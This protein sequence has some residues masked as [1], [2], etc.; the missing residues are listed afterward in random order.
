MEVVGNGMIAGVA[1][2]KAINEILLGNYRIYVALGVCMETTFL[3]RN[4]WT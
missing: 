2:N 1:L 3:R 4:I